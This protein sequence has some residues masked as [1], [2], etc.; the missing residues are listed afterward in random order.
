MRASLLVLLAAPLLTLPVAA[1]TDHTAPPWVNSTNWDAITTSYLIPPDGQ[2]GPVLN[3]PFS[4]IE[5]RHSPHDGLDGKHTDYLDTNEF[6]RD[7]K[8]RMR[9]QGSKIIVIFDPVIDKTFTLRREEKDYKESPAIYTSR[10]GKLSTA[11]AVLGEGGYAG[12]LEKNPGP[13]WRPI[14]HE[15]W[16]WYPGVFTP[17]NHVDTIDLGTLTISG[18]VCRGTRVTLTIPAL[19]KKNDIH[20]VRERWYS[21]NLQVLVESIDNDPRFGMST[22]QLKEIKFGEPDPSLSKL[23]EG[24]APTANRDWVKRR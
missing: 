18:L 22:Y 15:I 10:E 17:T 21:D 7:A 6:S 3:K 5:V 19:D 11:I 23:P 9:I 1:Q 20:I 24:Y 14:P 8:G 12:T 2:Q 13:V 4:A 16:G